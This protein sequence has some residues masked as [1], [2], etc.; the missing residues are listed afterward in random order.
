MLSLT[1]VIT[2]LGKAAKDAINVFYH[3]TYPDSVDW[4]A[5]TDEK[6][7]KVKQQLGYKKTFDNISLTV[8]EKQLHV[9]V[10]AL[11][12][13]FY[14]ITV[15]IVAE[16][17]LLHLYHIFLYRL[18]SSKFYSLVK[19]PFNLC[20][21]LTHSVSLLPRFILYHSETFLK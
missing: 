9:S 16:F 4:D 6:H 8:I 19:P 21:S 10:F 13:E 5:I 3:I 12:P 18:L 17:V 15:D 2:H 1:Y 20:L 11:A 14:G 7:L